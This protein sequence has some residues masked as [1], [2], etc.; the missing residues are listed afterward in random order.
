MRYRNDSARRQ[1]REVVLAVSLVLHQLPKSVW[2]ETSWDECL[3]L[4]EMHRKAN[5][6]KAEPGAVEELHDYDREQ[7]AAARAARAKKT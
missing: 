2:I 4:L 7:I 5:G 6:A 3:E 1:V